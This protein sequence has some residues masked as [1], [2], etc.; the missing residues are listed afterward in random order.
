M[1]ESVFSASI[2]QSFKDEII[3]RIFAMEDDHAHG[4]EV[5]LESDAVNV[6]IHLQNL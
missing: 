1:L 4:S 6:L 5:I 3:K 2:S